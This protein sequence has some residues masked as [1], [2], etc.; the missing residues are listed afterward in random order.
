MGKIAKLDDRACDLIWA[1]QRIP[2]VHAALK[3]DSEASNIV[4]GIGDDG[5]SFTV[6]DNGHGIQSQDLFHLVGQTP[7]TSKLELKYTVYGSRGDALL[8]LATLA[9]LTIESRHNTSWNCYRKVIEKRRVTFNGRISSKQC[10]PGTLVAVHDLFGSVPVRQVAYQ[11]APRSKLLGFLQNL[12]PRL[13]IVHATTSF[14]L[15]D[16]KC[17][18]RVLSLARPSCPLE[19]FSILCGSV[20]IT[21]PEQSVAWGNDRVSI[22]GHVALGDFGPSAP[23]WGGQIALLKRIGLGF[24][25]VGINGR[26]IPTFERD[27]QERLVAHLATVPLIGTPISI[28]EV[29][30]L[31]DDCVFI[32][33]QRVEFRDPSVVVTAFD[34]FLQS[35]FPSIPAAAAAPAVVRTKRARLDDEFSDAIWARSVDLIPPMR[36]TPAPFATASPLPSQVPTR[37]RSKYFSP[38][39]SRPTPVS[40][41]PRPR[42]L[43]PHLAAS[44]SVFVQ[45]AHASRTLSVQLTKASLA[46]VAVLGQ[47]DRKFILFATRTPTVL[48]CA[49]D[50]HAA[51]ER[52]RLEELEDAYLG[53]PFPRA[54]LEP[55]EQLQLS[56]AEF[57]VA[58]AHAATLRYWGFALDAAGVLATAP[59]VAQ[60]QATSG[61]CVEF[62]T[63]LVVAERDPPP[64]VTRL[65]HSRACRSAIMFGDALSKRECEELLVRLARCR[66]P[67]QCAHGR[68]SLA[69][70]LQIS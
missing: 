27:C 46:G 55:P 37:R 2:D 44:L 61:D 23:T 29:T 9:T 26:Y 70:L 57:A 4:I 40:P 38:T 58:S 11:A 65:L 7:A 12:L 13:A 51:D 25:V 33:N 22:A 5:L 20:A 6:Q 35:V 36:V 62:L 63:A 18:A 31:P 50:Q 53:R 14:E 30:C 21:L 66:L 34:A 3:E 42:R 1:T 69:P 43:Q 64:V 60:R 15:I 39:E 59:V 8:C 49:L 68:P 16:L 28:L 48:V 17:H 19:R 67:F 32:D 10:V 52:V 56:P 47:V 41:A 45:N 54:P 24:T